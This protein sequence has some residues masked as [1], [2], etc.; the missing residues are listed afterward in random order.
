[1]SI[2]RRLHDH[3]F[4]PAPLA[5][6][7]LVRV[8]L[9]ATQLTLLLVPWLA[10]DV[11]ICLGCD[12]AFH[13]WLGGVSTDQFQPLPV[14][15]LLLAPFG[16]GVRPS[17]GLLDAVWLTG[18]AAAV[19]S[20]LGLFTRASL[21]LLAGASTL[22]VAHAYSYGEQHHAEA[23]ITIALWTI[24]LA[25]SGAAWSLDDLRARLRRAARGERFTPHAG[26]RL[27]PHARWPLRLIQWL[28]VLIYLSAG[29]AK[30][31]N[32]GLEWFN[33]YTLAFYVADD[34]IDRGSALGVWFAS[35]I[36]LLK[37]VAIG[38]VVTELGFGGVMVWP[39]LTWLFILAGIGLHGGIYVLQRAPFPQ[40]VALYAVFVGE[41]RSSLP[42]AL[43]RTRARSPS[44]TGA[45]WT[46]VYDPTS[47]S[48]RRMAALLD[49]LDLGG[50]L[51]Y[52]AAAGGAAGEWH[53]RSPE[54]ATVHGIGRWRELAD[55]LPAL[56]PLRPFLRI[57]AAVRGG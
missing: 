45:W 19:T 2:T 36:T 34:A 44:N 40:L 52:E 29:T 35:Q 10:S 21:L 3:W 23:L 1:M 16:W 17:T 33:G 26:P 43:R 54:G 41:L 55:V 37:L 49:W 8:V 50:R 14:L 47:P 9:A 13:H 5:D 20:L 38:A 48:S 12:P 31:A 30:L 46:V 4:A 53:L 39:R 25:P 11:G 22:L 28:L 42:P 15:K 18:V 56:A 27:S 6:L 57:R 51:Q 32:G 7:A 24:A